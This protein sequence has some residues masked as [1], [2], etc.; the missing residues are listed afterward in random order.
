MVQAVSVDEN[1]P[2]SYV[3]TAPQPQTTSNQDVS[4][5]LSLPHLSGHGDTTT[6]HSRAP[7]YAC[8]PAHLLP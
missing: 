8:T 3:S 1:P 6:T 7:Y 2:A 5:A 4:D